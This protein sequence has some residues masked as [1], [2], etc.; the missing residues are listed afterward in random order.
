MRRLR[1]KPIDYL[2]KEEVEM[3]HTDSLDI[4]ES[5]GIKIDCDEAQR[6]LINNGAEQKGGRILIP[7]ELILEQLKQAPSQFKLH[8]FRNP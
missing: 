3:I 5:K 7:R 4:L 2:L 1:S 6:L 8:S